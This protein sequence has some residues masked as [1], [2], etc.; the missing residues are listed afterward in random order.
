[1]AR[2]SIR[3]VTYEG[4]KY[5]FDAALSDGINI[6]EGSNGKGKTTFANSIY[7][8]LGGRVESFRRESRAGHLEITSDKDNFVQLH[9]VIE[10]TPYILKRYIDTNDLGIIDDSGAVE[11]LP[12]IR[13]PN[14]PNIFSDWLLAKL[15][16][17]PV[18]IHLNYGDYSGKLGFTDIARLIYHNQS[19]D[20]SG[21]YKAPD[22]SNFVTDS[23]TFRK[24]IFEILIG[25]SFQPLY[26]AMAQLK[27]L[28]KERNLASSSLEAFKR[29]ILEVRP[30]QE[31]MNQI[32]LDRKIQ[33]IQDQL[34][35]A[36]AYRRSLAIR[37]RRRSTIDTTSPKS[38]L[39]L[40][41]M[42]SADLVRTENERLAELS[43]LQKLKAELILEVTQ[44]KK[45]MFAHEKL[46]I[47]SSNT[48]PYCLKEVQRDLNRCVCGAAIAEDQYQ[49]FFYTS[50]EYVHILKAKQ[51]NVDTI[52]LAID[53]CRQEIEGFDQ[54]LARLRKEADRIKEAIAAVV[55]Q[56][57]A[58]VDIA[59]FNVI[60]QQI[61]SLRH[62]LASLEQQKQLEAKREE[63]ER[64]SHDVNRR[65][66]A[67]HNE[68]N[69]LQAQADA[70][71]EKQRDRFSKKYDELMRE[72]L[73]DCHLAYIDSD[74]MPIFDAGKYRESSS[75]VPRRLN[76]YLTLLYLSLVDP[77]VRF[78]RFLL[79]D[80]PE[81]A[82]IDTDNLLSCLDQLTKIVG[83][84]ASAECQIILTTGI[85][86]YPPGLGDRVFETLT[87]N[88]RLL[89]PRPTNITAASY[90]KQQ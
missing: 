64:T 25:K 32:H 80:T 3:R 5:Y 38:D 66:E 63:L 43:R 1:M 74:Y 11:V 58:T 65:Y 16:I 34:E 54:E 26:Q 22:L 49:R 9:I 14:S 57:D 73:Q 77:E 87:D 62:T 30:N 81:T 4:T 78:P 56:A 44:I 35:K 7:F 20:P 37:P 67:K 40:V 68:Y 18:S 12:V 29:F 90:P 46:N 39:L 42:N 21:I 10:N 23:K 84:V 75:E 28:E 88:N 72:T 13:T 8:G 52:D 41:E 51:K 17:E 55:D 36:M 27:E 85:D 82:G 48:C 89:K 71:M 76:Y 6:L 33:E 19:A 59:N 70:E 79:I 24:A 83:P 2:L 50:E 53:S 69:Q 15:G 31:D 61:T 47:F 60:D 45:M 86:K